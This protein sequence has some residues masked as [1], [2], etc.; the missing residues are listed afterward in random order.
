MGM[1]RNI[2]AAITAITLVSIVTAVAL[3]V[4]AF[5]PEGAPVR[6]QASVPQTVTMTAPPPGPHHGGD[7]PL[8]PPSLYRGP[9]TL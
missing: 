3:I 1:F 7:R 8:R 6:A 9:W 5:V 2:D 4:I